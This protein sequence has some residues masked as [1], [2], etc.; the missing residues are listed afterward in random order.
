M[1]A[2]QYIGRG[3]HT[4]LRLMDVPCPHPAA[5]EILVRVMATSVNP[6]DWKLVNTALRFWSRIRF[7]YTPGFDLAG[8]VV[9]IGSRVKDFKVGDR[10]Y[11]CRG[12]RDT[13]TA[14]EFAVIKEVLAAPMP[15]NVDYAD[16]A[17][18]PLAGMTALQ[19]LRDQA[20]VKT[21][22]RVLIVG[23]AGGV[24][25]LM[26]QIAKY[27]GAH[28]TAV[29]GAAHVKALR[30]LGADDVIDTSRTSRFTR[31]TPYDVLIDAVGFPFDRFKDVMG[32]AGVF[33]TLLPDFATYVRRLSYRLHSTQKIIPMIM[34]PNG[35]DLRFLTGLIESGRLKPVIDCAY[36]LTRL[37]AAHKRSQLGH[38]Y[39]KISVVI[40]DDETVIMAQQA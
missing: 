10:V 38:G 2:M 6:I 22:D 30:A 36:P 12:L 14:S 11:G 5:R 25:H 15:K 16:A 7:P 34:K 1:K 18:I 26:V 35:Q 23:A 21:G 29:C 20:E 33:V 8:E 40:N 27:F 24:G 28:V 13:G 39:G 3:D 17:V 19:A 4:Q 31:L 32:P 9:E 37:A